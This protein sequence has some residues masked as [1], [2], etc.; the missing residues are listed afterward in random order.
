MP[1]IRNENPDRTKPLF[2]EWKN[3]QAARDGK[4]KLVRDGLNNRWSL[5]DINADPTEVNDLAE[6]YPQQVEKMDA[7]FQEWQKRVAIVPKNKR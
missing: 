6:K 4:W 1:V 3:G 2:W 7:M 5:F